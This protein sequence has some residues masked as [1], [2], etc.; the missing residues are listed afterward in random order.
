MGLGLSISYG[1]VERHGGAIEAANHPEGGAVFTARLPLEM[2]GGRR[3][4]RR[5]RRP[6]TSFP[7]AS[8]PPRQG[9]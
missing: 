6:A 1:I 9:T 3:R 5:E 8:S 2:A 4:P 7:P